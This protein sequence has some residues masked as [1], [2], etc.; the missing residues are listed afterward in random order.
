MKDS[1]NLYS[2]EFE[3]MYPVP[4]GM[5]VLARNEEDAMDIATK[6]LTHT[7]PISATLIDADKPKV[8]FFEDGDY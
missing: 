2:I 5:I 7:K 4:S 1:L 8:I 6:E 3:P